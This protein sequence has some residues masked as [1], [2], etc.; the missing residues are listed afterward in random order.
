[1][2]EEVLTAKVRNI[3]FFQFLRFSTLSQLKLY[4]R[5]WTHSLLSVERSRTKG[6]L[7]CFPSVNCNE[8]GCKTC[9]AF[10]T[11]SRFVIPISHFNAVWAQNMQWICDTYALL[12][13][14]TFQ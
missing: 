2:E 9:F 14:L 1:K 10:R 12:H 11:S 5:L 4:L 13:L 7:H 3:S 8:V 6:T